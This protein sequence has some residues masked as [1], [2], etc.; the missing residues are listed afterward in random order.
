MNK[1]VIKMKTITIN[2]MVP[3]K[4]K[5]LLSKSLNDE[6]KAELKTLFDQQKEHHPAS[7]I[8]L[9][10]SNKMIDLVKSYGFSIKADDI[11]D[12]LIIKVVKYPLILSQT[13]YNRLDK[14]MRI[15]KEFYNLLNQQQRAIES[16]NIDQYYLSY[17]EKK[18][19]RDIKEKE[20]QETVAKQIAE[21]KRLPRKPREKTLSPIQRRHPELIDI[22]TDPVTYSCGVTSIDQWLTP[23]LVKAKDGKEYLQIRSTYVDMS[24]AGTQLRKRFPEFECMPSDFWLSI[25]KR[26]E[27]AYKDSR[28]NRKNGIF[29]APQYKKREDDFSLSFKEGVDNNVRVAISKI[30]GKKYARISGLSN[31]YFPKGFKIN[32]YKQFVGRINKVS[33]IKENDKFYLTVG[34]YET[35]MLHPAKTSRVGIDIGIVNNIQ[36]STGEIKNLPKDR[37][38]FLEKKKNSLKSKRDRKLVKGSRKY[39]HLSLRV[40][41]I[42]RKIA[43]IRKYHLTRF[44]VE[45]VKENGTIAIE[46]LKIKNMTKSASGD[47]ESPGKKVAQKTGLNKSILRVAPYM[48][49]S[50]LRN[51]TKEYNRVLFEVP[52]QFT[53]QTC[54]SCGAV[55]KANRTTQDKFKCISCGFESNADL[56]AAINILAKA[57]SA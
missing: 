13:E 14:M 32:Y 48:F 43:N 38:L 25:C 35:P 9:E 15:G 3:K 10:F 55:D 12:G 29:R 56:N 57:E 37:I 26:V 40:Q 7:E 27:K 22:Q 6:Q 31:K 33:I 46:D 23:V 24:R 34:Y 2:S 11:K 36:L 16:Y 28:S 20:W 49:K 42:E 54:S 50:V 39:K 41:K 52:P 51:K 18:Q 30:N 5:A 47:M 17:P 4:V 53:S 1:Q 45:I 19:E 21:G 8:N 44:A